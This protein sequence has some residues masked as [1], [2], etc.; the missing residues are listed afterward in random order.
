MQSKN[1]FAVQTPE[2]MSAEEVLSLFVE[3]STDYPHILDQSHSM[4]YGPRG[5]GKSM[6]FR[7]ME[8]DCQ[9]KHRDCKFSELNFFG[10]YVPVKDASL[11]ISE[12]ERFQ[13]AKF[14]PYIINE[15]L[16]V[17]HLSSRLFKSLEER[18][19]IGEIETNSLSQ[20]WQDELL[21]RLVRSGAENNLSD[22]DVKKLSLG[23]FSILKR[24]FDKIFEDGVSYIKRA[25]FLASPQPYSGPLLGYGDFLKPILIALSRLDFM[26]NCPIYIL[27]DDADNL[28]RVQT[29]ILNSWIASR[30][31]GHFCIKAAAETLKYKTL[32]TPNGRRIEMPH[33]FQE[34]KIHDIYTT[35]FDTYKT[36]ITQ[37]VEK[38]LIAS[39]VKRSA[40]DFFPES[41][42]QVNK[43]RAISQS[44]NN[45]TDDAAR[46]YRASDDAGRYSRPDYI[47]QLKG[48]SK[49][50]ATYSYAG[51]DQLVHVSSGV[52]RNFLDPASDMFSEMVSV[53]AQEEVHYITHQIQDKII[54][55]RAKEMSVTDFSNMKSAEDDP[56]AIVK[57]LDNLVS[58]LGGM[59]YEILISEASDRRVFSI[60]FSN[61]PDDEVQEVLDLGVTKGYFHQSSIGNKKGN[62]RVPLYILSRRLAPA[63]SLDPTSFSG[64]KFVTND[65][66]LAAI[67]SPSK[68]L[69]LVKIKGFE[70]IMDQNKQG[71]LFD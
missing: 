60:A 8:P 46:G 32:K 30:T 1:P 6:I 31:T 71:S 9:T 45:Q 64:Y 51:F 33:D 11:D 59:F 58:A 22:D 15:H 53:H 61:G 13:K 5:S 57:K 70:A 66:I 26:P 19:K 56:K 16:L 65:K 29:E 7:F 63:F 47:K 27:I 67:H 20:Y 23:D 54:K 12:L 44:Y 34:I 50:G 42:D 28:N 2:S 38:R 10:V 68:L 52:I 17:A 41:E 36:R 69:D 18:A 21:P 4:I 43:I 35:K 24:C 55:R 25:G 14:S 48:T 49:S 39:G 40:S 37:I 3:E 62:G